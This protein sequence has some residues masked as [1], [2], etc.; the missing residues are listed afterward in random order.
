MSAFWLFSIHLMLRSR[1]FFTSDRRQLNASVMICYLICNKSGMVQMPYS[2]ILARSMAF[3]PIALQI[4]CML[5]SIAGTEYY[6]KTIDGD[7]L[8]KLNVSNENSFC[9]CFVHTFSNCLVAFSTLLLGFHST[10]C[11]LRKSVFLPLSVL[12]FLWHFK[13]LSSHFSAGRHAGFLA[14]FLSVYFAKN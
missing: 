13:K 10:L 14:C 7:G 8:T 12:F 1:S 9:R 2:T 6:V 3:M 4:C 5:S 11:I